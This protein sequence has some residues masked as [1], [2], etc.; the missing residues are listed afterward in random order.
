MPPAPSRHPVCFSRRPQP[1]QMR[2]AV[3]VDA[4]GAADAAGAD[5]A[6]ALV[7]PG[8]TAR[9]AAGGTTASE[10][11]RSYRLTSRPRK[12]P[13]LFC[14]GPWRAHPCNATRCKAPTLDLVSRFGSS[15]EFSACFE[16][17]FRTK[18][19]TSKL[20][21]SGVFLTPKFAKVPAETCARTSG[22]GH[23]RA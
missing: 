22:S 7:Q 1:P 9:G 6:G 18:S 16:A 20:G 21:D 10:R 2:D 23:Q 13:A 4:A 14:A 17:N 5:V 19:D 3:G 15:P 12:R 11:L 8:A